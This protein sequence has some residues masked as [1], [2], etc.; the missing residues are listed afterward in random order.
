[1]VSGSGNGRR[2]SV[3]RSRRGRVNA[4]RMNARIIVPLAIPMALG[5]ALGMVL[6]LSGGP[7]H[8]TINPAALGASADPSPTASTSSPAATQDANTSCGLI[9]P[10]NAL[11]ARGLA[12]PWQLTGPNGNDPEGSGCTMANATN[13]G[14][15]VQAT[16]LNPRTGQLF[17]YEPL[18]ITQGTTPAAAPVVPKLPRGAIVNIMVG[19]NGANLQLIGAQ[20]GALA[21]S[22]CVNGLGDSLFG[23]V[24][25]C[26]SAAFYQAAKIDETFGRLRIPA[27]GTSPVTGQSCPTTRSF[28]IVDQD[29]SDN[30]TTQY[31]LTADGRTAQDNGANQAALAGA[32]RVNN[33]SDNLLLDNFILPT[34]QCTPF[35][36][37]DL[38]AGGA[39]ATS[40]TLDELSAARYQ[41]APVAL[42]PENDPMTTLD[43]AHSVQKTNLYRIGVG[44]PLLGRNSGF[45]FTRSRFGGGG[46]QAD[47]P[48]NYCANMLNLE[49]PFI[50]ANAARFGGV[51]SP[52]ADTG[53]NLFTFMAA[54]LS[55]SFDNMNCKDFGLTNPVNLTLDGN[56]VAINATLRLTKQTPGASASPSASPSAI[57]TS[58]VSPSASPSASASASSGQAP[59][60][61]STPWWQQVP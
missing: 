58:S 60:D 33:G 56:G 55:G 2:R 3:N 26:N 35:T 15:F 5:L 21:Q 17:V 61:Q 8:T 20:P 28:E 44:Q 31:L 59:T 29:Q 42:V 4:R 32:S 16:I 12:T 11:T 27:I 7:A 13:L 53:N 18:V 41:R 23:Q 45:P 40:Q 1:M 38:S 22:R 39:Q 34:L 52:V 57:P 43:G 25:Y 49:T 6:A 48:A 47:T 36:A 37:P 14:A 46:Q 51:A 19:F 30:V 24:S 50:A 10:A 9:V 54:R